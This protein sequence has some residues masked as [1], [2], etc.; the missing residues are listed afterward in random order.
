MPNFLR[1]VDKQTEQA[2]EGRGLIEVDEK[3]CAGLGVPCDEKSFYMGWVDW[4]TLYVTDDWA[5]VREMYVGHD[6][7]E[8][9]ELRKPILDWLEEHYE[10]AG[11]AMIGRRR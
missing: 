1:L 3:L 5:K 8:R 10:L 2:H 4:D 11:Y 7:P 9:A 6:T